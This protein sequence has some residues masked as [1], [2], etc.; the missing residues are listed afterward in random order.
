MFEK[1]DF[2]AD[3]KFSFQVLFVTVDKKVLSKTFG[4]KKKIKLPSEIG[5]FF[6]IFVFAVHF[7]SWTKTHA[8]QRILEICIFF[9]SSK[10]PKAEIYFVNSGIKR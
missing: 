2:F 7:D 6:T 8:N 3:K 5:A 10:L 4:V 9:F 1:S